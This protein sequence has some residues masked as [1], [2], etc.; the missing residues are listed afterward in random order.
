MTTK[1]KIIHTEFNV[2]ED[3]PKYAYFKMEKLK[4]R[5]KVE[6]IYNEELNKLNIE[7]RRKWGV[8]SH[9]DYTWW[10]TYG[11]KAFDLG[12]QSQKQKIIEEINNLSNPYPLDIFPKVELSEF[13]SHT[14]NDFLCSHLRV[15]LD[16]LSAELMRRAR[17]TCKLEILKTLGEKDEN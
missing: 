7:Y 14:I 12:I 1:D 6:E 15:T 4:E 17:E 11:D 13:Q 8:A 10:E 16:G 9:V 3:K 5:D 2:I